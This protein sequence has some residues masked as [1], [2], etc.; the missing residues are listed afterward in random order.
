MKDKKLNICLLLPCFHDPNMP[1]MG[2]TEIYN[3]YGKYFPSFDHKVTWIAPSQEKIGEV[4]EGFF[5][6]VRVYNIPYSK[7]SSLLMRIFN[8]LL[9]TFREAK[10]VTTIFKKENYDIIQVRTNIFVEC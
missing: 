2:I 7:Y 4:Q 9:F 5:N 8:K 3:I 1:V 6:K 10:F